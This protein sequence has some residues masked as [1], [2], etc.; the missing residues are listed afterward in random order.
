MN[1][2]ERNKN[3]IHTFFFG[4][5]FI[6]KIKLNTTYSVNKIQTFGLIIYLCA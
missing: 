2:C 1:R 4:N 3:K 6:N 5:N